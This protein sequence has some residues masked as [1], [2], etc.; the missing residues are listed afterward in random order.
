MSAQGKT[1]AIRILESLGV[2]F[3]VATYAVGDEHVD[4]V[5]AAREMGVEPDIVFKTLVAHDEK[6]GILVFCVPGPAELDLKKAARAAGVRKVDLVSLRDLTP[7][8]GYVR[9]GCSPIGMKKRFPTWIDEMA[10]AYPRIYVNAGA[11]GMQVLIAPADLLAAT[12]AS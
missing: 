2:T 11:R 9:G 5:T 4:A 8:T 12:G 7:L 10:G 1:N 3:D 6:N